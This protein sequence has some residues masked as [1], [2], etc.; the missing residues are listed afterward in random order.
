MIRQGFRGL[1]SGLDMQVCRGFHRDL[2]GFTDV[3]RVLM[4]P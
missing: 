4:Q 3:L 1:V 2:S